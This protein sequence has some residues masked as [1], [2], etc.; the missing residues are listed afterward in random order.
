MT[1]FRTINVTETRALAAAL[2]DV[3]EIGDLI[4]LAGEMGAGKTA[5]TQGFAK[6]LGIEEQ[7][8]SPTFTLVRSYPIEKKTGR[9]RVLH[10]IDVYRLERLHE[11]IDLGIGELIDE[12]SVT[13]IEWGDVVTELLPP[14]RVEVRILFGEQPEEREIRMTAVG[15]PW[16]S[17]LQ[18]FSKGWNATC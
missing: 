3:A 11:V 2:A 18:H 7:V 10:H 17:R 15:L 13:V 9:P 6:G 16:Q 8:T 5:F 14:D 12:Q 1:T 4:V